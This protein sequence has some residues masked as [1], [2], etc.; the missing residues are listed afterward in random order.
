MSL[1]KFEQKEAEILGGIKQR[2]LDALIQKG[3]V[4]N[5]PKSGAQAGYLVVLRY[6]DEFTSKIGEFS[7]EVN[8]ALEGRALVYD[9]ANIHQTIVDFNLQEIPTSEFIPD[10]KILGGLSESTHRALKTFKQHYLGFGPATAFK[11][12]LNSPDSVILTPLESRGNYSL[13][14]LIASEA[15]KNKLEVR[16]AWGRHVTVNRFTEEV[17]LGE[18]ENFKQ[19]LERANSEASFLKQEYKAKRL[20]IGY[21]ILNK[22]SFALHVSDSLKI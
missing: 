19:L 2:G 3:L 15:Q 5:I 13:I 20:D 22:Q 4:A 12:Y 10:R 8:W 6:G 11:E 17:P 7:L 14:E 1:Q 16:K 9:E 18:L 21:F